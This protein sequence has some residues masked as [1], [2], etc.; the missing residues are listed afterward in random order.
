MRQSS[1]TLLV[2]V[3]ICAAGSTAA[4]EEASLRIAAVD[5][6]RLMEQSPYA[7]DVGERLRQEFGPVQR[8]LSAM[9][10]ELQAMDA[11][12]TTQ[13]EFMTD[14][15]RVQLERDMGRMNRQLQLRSAE[16]QEDVGLRNNEEV[17]RLQNIVIQAVRDYS[18]AEG[19]DLVLADG[20]VYHADRIDITEPVMQLLQ[21][22][23][24][25][26]TAGPVGD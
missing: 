6:A 18:E 23:Y 14:Q 17:L 3:L 5:L 7:E 15:D 9:Q 4:A 16:Y 13:G 8:E 26:S 22:R 20:I 10:Q 19:Y 2:L 11:R 12:L 1:R 25:A 21:Q 24:R